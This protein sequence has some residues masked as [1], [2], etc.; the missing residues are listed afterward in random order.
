MVPHVGHD[1]DG[2]LAG[3]MAALRAARGWSLDDLAH[4]AGA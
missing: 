4:R 3:H 1:L 2:R